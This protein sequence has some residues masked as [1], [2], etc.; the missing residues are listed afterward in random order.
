MGAGKLLSCVFVAY[1]RIVGSD[2]LPSVAPG[3]KAHI[4]EGLG[5]KAGFPPKFD[6]ASVVYG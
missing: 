3:W 2:V 1:T 5:A 4:A 6:C